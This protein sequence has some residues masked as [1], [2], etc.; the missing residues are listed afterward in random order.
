MHLLFF[1]FHDLVGWVLLLWRTGKLAGYS[2]CCCCCCCHV[3]VVVSLSL[4]GACWETLV[5]HSGARRKM[6]LLSSFEAAFPPLV[7]PLTRKWPHNDGF[8]KV[9]WQRFSFRVW[10]PEPCCR[11]TCWAGD[12]CTCQSQEPAVAMLKKSSSKRQNATQHGDG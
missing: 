3:R 9:W 4:S 1:D 11:L 6:L 10:K 5:S 12:S 2:C 7:A 8:L